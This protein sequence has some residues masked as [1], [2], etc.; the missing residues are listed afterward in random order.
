MSTAPRDSTQNL[1]ILNA[2]LDSLPWSA[3]ELF[4]HYF[5]GALSQRVPADQWNAALETAKR[6]TPVP[7]QCSSSPV[8]EV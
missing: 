3:S 8:Q 5:I 1:S 4:V 6:L 7:V 2:A